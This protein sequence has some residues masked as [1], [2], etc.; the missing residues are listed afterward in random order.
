MRNLASRMSGMGIVSIAFFMAAC[1]GPYGQDQGRIADIPTANPLPPVSNDG[2]LSMSLTDAPVDT[3]SEVVISVSAVAIKPVDGETI[4]FNFD[5]TREFDLLTLQGG[6]TAEVLEAT[7]IPAGDYQWARITVEAEFDNDF[8]SYAMT[9]NGMVE[10]RVPGV[11]DGHIYMT[12]GFAISA[13]ETTEMVID[14]DLRKALS[15]PEGQP[16]YHLRPTVRVADRKSHGT[17]NGT[18]ATALLSGGG[19]TNDLALDVGSAIYVYPAGA[20]LLG[21]IGNVD[22]EPFATAS[23]RQGA[24]GAYEFAVHF[25]PAGDYAAAFTCQ[26]SDDNP[27]AVDAISLSAP[28]NFSIENGVITALDFQ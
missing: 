4:R 3:A 20:A 18:I 1:S 5:G 10:I 12:D 28:Q 13:N 24:G 26:A 16:G 23:V 17:L 6:I 9:P 8:D 11:T 21:D 27:E 2:M 15:A 25:L 22:A 14:W 7:R 19:C